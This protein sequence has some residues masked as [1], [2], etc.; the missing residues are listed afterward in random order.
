MIGFI[1]IFCYNASQAQSIIALS[2]IYPLHQSVGH[3]KSS[4]S[5]LVVS[6]QQICN[7]LTVTTA[8]IKSYFRMLTPLYSFAILLFSFSFFRN[9]QLRNST[10]LYPH[11]TDPTENTAC[12][13]EKACLPRLCLAIDLLFRAFAS[14]GMYLS[15][16]CLALDMARTTW[17]TILAIP[18]L[19]LRAL[20]SGVA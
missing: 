4:Q 15:T 18:F 16:R 17:K 11:C 9:C 19:L 10:F 12:I 13:A 14:A 6:W 3:A 7:S 20:I 2:L 8:H 5:S 1:N